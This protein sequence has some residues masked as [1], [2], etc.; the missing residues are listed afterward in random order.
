[1]LRRF[2]F[3]MNHPTDSLFLDGGHLDGIVRG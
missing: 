1:M 3:R 2:R